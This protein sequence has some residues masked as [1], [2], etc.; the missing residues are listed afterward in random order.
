M[1]SPIVVGIDPG[2]KHNGLVSLAE[3]GAVRGTQTFDYDDL[4]TAVEA[5]PQ[6]EEKLDVKI[7]IC[8]EVYQ[9]YPQQQR[10]QAWNDFPVVQIIGVVKYLSMKNDHHLVMARPPDVN[11]FMKYRQVPKS[12]PR[13]GLGAHQL[14]AYR[15]AEYYRVMYLSKQTQETQ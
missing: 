13:S 5:F 8:M 7:Y 6:V 4:I 1:S 3:D 2:D 12:I 11:R 9:L 10:Y 15:L 14:S